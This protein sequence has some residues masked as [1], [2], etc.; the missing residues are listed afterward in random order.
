VS[1]NKDIHERLTKVETII[2]YH[3]QRMSKLEGNLNDLGHKMQE[4]IINQNALL[5]KFNTLA[6]SIETLQT[7]LTIRGVKWFLEK[8]ALPIAIAV[9]AS[10]I[11]KFL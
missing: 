3:E 5:E 1:D 2:Q 9:A 8:M 10:I 4:V 6:S 11:L 7:N